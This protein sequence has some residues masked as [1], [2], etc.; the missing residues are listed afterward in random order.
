VSAPRYLPRDLPLEE[1]VRTLVEEHGKMKD[2]LQQAKAA[3]EGGNFGELS[4]KLRLLDPIFKQHIADEE[5][6]ILRL[7]IEVLGVKGAQDEI[8][9][10]Q[11]HRPIYSLMLT[12]SELAAK[13]PADLP[14]E[15]ARLNRLF[16]EHATAEESRVFP[17]ALRV[18]PKKASK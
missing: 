4:E 7:L 11:Q 12:V 2:L 8:R 3:A 10:F 17:R 16:D 9:V 14:S 13:N 1:L 6:Q 5:G 18:G 15:E